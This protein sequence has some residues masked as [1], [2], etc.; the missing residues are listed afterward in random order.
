MAIE[1]GVVTRAE[2][3]IVGDLVR[4]LE[5]EGWTARFVD[6]SGGRDRILAKDESIVSCVVFGY[7][8]SGG[9]AAKFVEL[10]DA[11]ALRAFDRAVE[12][13][14]SLDDDFESFGEELDLDLELDEDEV[15]S[16]YTISAQR[17]ARDFAE[18]LHEVLLTLPTSEAVDL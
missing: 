17:G 3:E 12:C 18:A 1:L 13:E 4:L 16:L 14:L 8:L 5:K 9:A 15:A 7:D 2:P 11:D 10:S 6:D